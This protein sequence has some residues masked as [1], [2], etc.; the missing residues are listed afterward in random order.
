MAVALVSFL[1]NSS[2]LRMLGRY[3]ES[4]VH[5]RATWVFTRADVIA[6]VG[7][8]LSGPLVL[9]TGS[10]FPDLVGGAAI[11]IYVIKEAFEIVSEAR[12]DG[13]ESR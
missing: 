5:L 13:K 12:E 2:V 8:M 9:L 10:R 6:S 4:E 1:V 7:V 11:G 3:R